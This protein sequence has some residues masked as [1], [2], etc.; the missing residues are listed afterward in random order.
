M[1]LY[2]E[3]KRACD[4]KEKGRKARASKI[5]LAEKKLSVSVAIKGDYYYQN[6]GEMVDSIVK[7]KLRIFQKLYHPNPKEMLTTFDLKHKTR[8]SVKL[9][10][11]SRLN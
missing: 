3:L 10:T 2:N 5:Q 6:Y 1:Q 7:S 8:L 11:K 9:P 4:I